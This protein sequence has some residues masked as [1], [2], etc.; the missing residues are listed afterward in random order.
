M[1]Q[2][3]INFISI[4]PLDGD[5]LDKYEALIAF[6]NDFK[7]KGERF[8]KV[9]QGKWYRARSGSYHKILVF[10]SSTTAIASFPTSAPFADINGAG[11][12]R[13]RLDGRIGTTEHTHDLVEEVC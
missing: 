11:Y 7:H 4:L 2:E 12:M 1:K 13:V 6:V 8:E 9:Q 3:L 10:D 5:P